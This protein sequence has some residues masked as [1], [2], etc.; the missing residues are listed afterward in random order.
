MQLVE[1]DGLKGG[2][3]GGEESSSA[4]GEKHA[5]GEK[6]L[7]GTCLALGYG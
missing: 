1:C 3:M 6:R 4:R 7:M 2:C 5:T